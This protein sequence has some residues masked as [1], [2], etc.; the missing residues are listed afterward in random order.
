MSI[1]RHRRPVRLL[2]RAVSY[3]HRSTER[4]D[5]LGK[6]CRRRAVLLANTVLHLIAD[7]H[8]RSGLRVLQ[9]VP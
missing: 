3:V 2:S 7:D 5:R 8:T 1:F 9:P 6:V 4:H